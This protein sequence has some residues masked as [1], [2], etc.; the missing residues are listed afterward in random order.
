MEN[1]NIKYRVLKEENEELRQ[2]NDDQKHFYLEKIKDLERKNQELMDEINN[3][4]LR[5][6]KINLAHQKEKKTLILEYEAKIN[7]LHEKSFQ[8]ISHYRQKS[9]EHFTNLSKNIQNSVIS[10]LENTKDNAQN[11]NTRLQADSNN[12]ILNKSV[13]LNNNSSRLS[14]PEANKKVLNQS[15]QNSNFSGKKEKGSSGKKNLGNSCLGK[16]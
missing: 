10:Y 16:I 15:L 1:Q 4:K 14:S 9:E 5:Q 13:E 12:L 7:R 6:E 11:F 8:Q 2:I 3:E